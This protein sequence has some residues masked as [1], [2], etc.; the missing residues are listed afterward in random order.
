MSSIQWIEQIK[1]EDFI[2]DED[3]SVCLIT[4]EVFEG[5]SDYTRSQPTNPAPGRIY[6][7]NLGWPSDMPDNWFAYWCLQDP[8]DPTYVLH[9][10]RKILIVE[11]EK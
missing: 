4:R 11:R 3:Q 1:N 10:G 5:L 2:F 7:K 8:K 6:K 9:H